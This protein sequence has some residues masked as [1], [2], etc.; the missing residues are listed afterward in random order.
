[1]PAYR[2]PHISPLEITPKDIY[3]SRRSFIGA[4]AAA[5]FSLAA[6]GN[7]WAAPLSTV[8]GPYKLNEKLTPK[9][10]VTTYNNFYEFGVNKE[11][12]SQNSG[13]FKPTPWSVKVEG[14]VGK[15]KEFGLEEILKMKLEDRTYRM[16]CVEG[17][18]MVIPW[19]GF[20]L[21]AIIDQVE[22]LGSAKYVAF[23]TVV[24]PEEMPGQGGLFQPLP[25]PYIEG[26]RM[27]EARHPLTIL[28]VGLYGET[29]PNQNGAP[30]RLVVPWKYGFKSIKS[31]VK[32]K[33]V[34]EQPQTTWKNSNA[35]EYGFYS[36][37]NPAVDHPRWSQA[38]EQRIGEGGFF[39]T[40]RVDTLPFNGYANEVASL[41][42]GMDLKANY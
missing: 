6:G 17:W 33:L 40:K 21:S 9:E 13:A 29:L 3:L 37:V 14:M 34:E 11:D 15:P 32:I 41:Y 30:I 22:P 10:A 18:S 1:M 4:A 16:R 19:I 8:P 24:R 23:E 28:A 20:P 38:T 42:S 27:D 26:L 7:A 36:N 2:P 25:W 39:G 5:G 12:P 31:I 35:R